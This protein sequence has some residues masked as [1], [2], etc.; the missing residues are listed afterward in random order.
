MSRHKPELLFIKR[1]NYG[2]GPDQRDGLFCR[3]LKGIPQKL[4]SLIDKLA[5]DG[6]APLLPSTGSGQT[7]RNFVMYA[8]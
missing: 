1:G 3:H 7:G 5:R 8:V 6:A 2:K 4:A